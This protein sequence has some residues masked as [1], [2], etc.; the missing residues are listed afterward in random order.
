METDP[1]NS[2]DSVPLLSMQ[3]DGGN[4]SKTPVHEPPLLKFEPTSFELLVKILTTLATPSCYW[5]PI[6]TH[7][8]T[9]LPQGSRLKND[10]V[11][12]GF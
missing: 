12:I 1:C 6:I 9:V 5:R 10:Q 11:E 7:Q 4:R 8:N 2:L 3:C